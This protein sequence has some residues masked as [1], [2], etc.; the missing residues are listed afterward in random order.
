MLYLILISDLPLWLDSVVDTITFADDTS[1]SVGGDSEEE[2]IKILEENSARIFQ[3]FSSNNLVAN[4]DKTCFLFVDKLKGKQG[5]GSRE[6]R[7]GNVTVKES[8]AEKL[9]GVKIDNNH[10]WS[11]QVSDSVNSINHNLFQMRKMR[12]KVTDEQMRI[13]GHGMVMSK[14]N[15]ACSA[16]GISYLQSDEK[17]QQVDVNKRLQKNVKMTYS[18]W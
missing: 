8:K 2:V 5:Q 6:L 11:D 10:D 9:L 16:Y 1:I 4:K 7:I 12:P 14:L 18:E 15:Y 3:Y 17:C 13:F